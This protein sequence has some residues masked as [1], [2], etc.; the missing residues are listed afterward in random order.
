MTQRS[1]APPTEPGGR[2]RVFISYSREDI[3]FAEQLVAALEL[4][5]FDVMLDRHGITGGEDFQRRLGT[6][7]R[8]AD[9]VVFVLSPHS[10][11]SPMCAWEVTEASR[12]GKRIIPILCRALQRSDPPPALKNLDYIFFYAEP[13][14]IGSGFGHGLVRLVTALNTDLEW[15]REHTR[16]LARATEWDLA[17]R[18]DNRLLSGPDIG[19]AKDWASR[20]PKGAPE[21]TTLHLDYIRA[22]ETAA[23]LRLNAER[24]RLDEITRIQSEREA[25]L[26]TAEAAQQEKAIA[27]RRLLQRTRAGLAVAVSLALIA[28]IAGLYAWTNQQTANE[29]RGRAERN[30]AAVTDALAILDNEADPKRIAQNFFNLAHNYLSQDRYDEAITLYQRSL[31]IAEKQ[32]GP[33]SEEVASARTQTGIVF[34]KIKKYDQAEALLKEA[35]LYHESNPSADPQA[36]PTILAAL[37]EIYR[38]QGRS[39]E[40]DAANARARQVAL[41]NA[42]DM[43]PVFFATDRGRVLV[44]GKLDYNDDRVRRLELGKADVSVPK[45]HES[46]RLERP[47]SIKVPLLDV[48]LYEE[49]EDPRK[50]FVIQAVQPLSR[51]SFVDAAK[52]RATGSRRY[53]GHILVFIHGPA[54]SFQAALFRTA[55]LAYN[56][57]F[58]AAPMLYSWP[59]AASATSYIRDRESATQA[60]PYLRDFLL[61]LPTATG[62]SKISIIAYSTGARPLLSVLRNLRLATDSLPIEELILVAP[63]V[64]RDVFEPIGRQL[65]GVAK[66]ITLYVSGADRTLTSTR[67]LTAGISRAGEMSEGSAPTIIPGIDTIDVTAIGGENLGLSQSSYAP[68]SALIGDIERLLATGARPP[69]IRSPEL[70]RVQTS[71]GLYWRYTAR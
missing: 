57:R 51:S 65:R 26:K 34:T 13:K 52:E 30:L 1:P 44:G 2:L 70:E 46:P 50:H 4:T 41:A 24:Q 12:L 54:T 16:L 47:W 38:A 5:G 36:V 40:A 42:A 9:T 69:D 61:W 58:D 11:S 15:L 39:A 45:I 18:V 10:A 53:P 64:D 56:L 48:G 32:F 67:G 20:R 49:A 62:A 19:L 43:V 17:G 37:A 8:E 25:A 6:L 7:V 68:R 31:A 60:E 28:C 66:G 22:S 59:A 21:P 3:D 63:D 71:D 33:Q 14:V 55:H 23:D 27:S 35:L 29:Q